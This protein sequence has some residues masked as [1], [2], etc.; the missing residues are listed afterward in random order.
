MQC[1]RINRTNCQHQAVVLLRQQGW[2]GC[3]EYEEITCWTALQD[4]TLRYIIDIQCGLLDE[5]RI[6][7]VLDQEQ[8]ELIESKQQLLVSQLLD[9]VNKMPSEQRKQFLSALDRTQL[10][11][12]TW[13]LGSAHLQ[14]MDKDWTK[15]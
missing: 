11:H 12:V 1:I 5:L 15:L 2:N 6:K 3:K 9:N 4:P 10:S 14:S 13:Q 7:A 8:I